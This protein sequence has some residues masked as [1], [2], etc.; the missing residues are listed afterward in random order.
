MYTGRTDRVCCLC[1]D[2]EPR[3]HIEVPPRALTLLKNAEPIAW[4]D[5]DGPVTLYFCASDWALVCDL[6]LDAGMHPLGR[7]NA[8]RAE[9]TLRVDYEAYLNAV[10][11]APDQAAIEAR[12]RERARETLSGCPETRERVQARIVLLALE[13]LGPLP[14][15]A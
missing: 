4:R 2:P 11:E 7:C 13:E 5:V 3:T 14:D 15:G 6:V 9:F 12:F 8:A 1:A 10:R